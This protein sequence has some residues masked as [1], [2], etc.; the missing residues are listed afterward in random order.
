MPS[1][2]IVAT[3][4]RPAQSGHPRRWGWVRAVA[5]TP[6][7]RWVTQW[8]IEECPLGGWWPRGTVQEWVDRDYLEVAGLEATVSLGLAVVELLSTQGVYLS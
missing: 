8:A 3:R 4:V 6:H 2:R 7:G 1:L 5:D